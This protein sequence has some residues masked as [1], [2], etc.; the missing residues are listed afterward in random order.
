MHPV[1]LFQ[2]KTPAESKGGWDL[3]KQIDM[4]PAAEAW[5]PMKEESCPLIGKV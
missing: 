4:I 1:Y 3:Y 2:V 5:R